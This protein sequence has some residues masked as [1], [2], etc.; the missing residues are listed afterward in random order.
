MQRYVTLSHVLRSFR[1]PN[2]ADL[3]GYV[4]AAV[5][6]FFA[7]RSC[8]APERLSHR[9]QDAGAALDKNLSSRLCTDCS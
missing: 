3:Q 9:P 6:E 7:P 1:F 2:E 4:A 5:G 8:S